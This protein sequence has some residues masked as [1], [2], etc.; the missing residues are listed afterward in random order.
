MFTPVFSCQIYKC[1]WL[2]IFG[3][4]GSVLLTAQ[5]FIHLLLVVVL[6]GG[7]EDIY[8]SIKWYDVRVTWGWG[9]LCWA[10]EKV[11]IFLVRKVYFTY[12]CRNKFYDIYYLKYTYLSGEHFWTWYHLHLF[13]LQTKEVVSWILISWFVVWKIKGKHKLQ[14]QK[15]S[16]MYYWAPVNL[17]AKFQLFRQTAL[18]SV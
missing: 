18:Q 14:C 10:S 1:L 8:I 9:K 13:H 5:M 11:S 16:W 3:T 4:E 6:L 7:E 2:L 17:M 15:W 12:N